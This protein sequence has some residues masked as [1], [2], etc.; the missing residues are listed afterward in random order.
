[1]NLIKDDQAACKG[2]RFFVNQTA[3]TGQCK[4]HAP[5]VVKSHSMPNTEF[6]VTDDVSFMWPHVYDCDWCGDYEAKNV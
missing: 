1:M 2:C 4:R 6:Q 5:I 3:L